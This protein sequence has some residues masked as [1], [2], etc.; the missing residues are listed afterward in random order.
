MNNIN[1]PIFSANSAGTMLKD[2]DHVLN[3]AG[4]VGGYIGTDN[5]NE[6][7]FKAAHS[8][9]TK[10]LTIVLTCQALTVIHTMHAQQAYKVLPVM[11]NSFKSIMQSEAE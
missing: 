4:S 2:I 7:V 9:V 8:S 10:A 1:L 5:A 3:L 11:V 6:V